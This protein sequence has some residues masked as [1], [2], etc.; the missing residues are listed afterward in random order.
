LRDPELVERVCA[1]LVQTAQ[2]QVRSAEPLP[3]GTGEH[4]RSMQFG[5][6]ATF[7]AGAGPRVRFVTRPPSGHLGSFLAR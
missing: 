5:V 6:P 3:D 1:Q 2:Q 4:A 7:S